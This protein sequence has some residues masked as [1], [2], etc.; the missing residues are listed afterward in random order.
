M[1]EAI[2]PYKPSDYP[3][4]EKVWSDLKGTSRVSLLLM[5]EWLSL[6]SNKG[7]K[8][9]FASYI[10]ALPAPGSLGTPF[11]WAEE[12]LQNFPYQPLVKSVSLQRKR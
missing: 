4:F 10:E 3:G 7:S 6:S 9:K 2:L 12:N 11:H 8:S 1:Y 5:K